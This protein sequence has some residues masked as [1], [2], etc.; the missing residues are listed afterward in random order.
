MGHLYE[1]LK[2]MEAGEVGSESKGGGSPASGTAHSHKIL[3]ECQ[4]AKRQR[5]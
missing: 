5:S 4:R 2:A 3:A 1:A